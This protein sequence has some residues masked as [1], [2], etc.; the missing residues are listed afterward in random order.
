MRIKE[1]KNN[2]SFTLIEILVIFFFIV[3]GILGAIYFGN[4][5]G[6]IGYVLGFASGCIGVFIS[7]VVLAGLEDFFFGGIPRIP[8]CKNNK[9]KGPDNYSIEEIKDKVLVRKCNCGDMYIKKGRKFLEID[10]DG[11]E[12]K[13]LIWIPFKGWKEDK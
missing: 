9:C 8:Y 6:I 7:I 4:K 2:N 12:K 10:F 1:I 11:N 3:I 5:F 13:Y